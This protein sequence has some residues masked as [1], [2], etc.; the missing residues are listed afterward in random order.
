MFWTKQ[1]H[2]HH[3]TGTYISLFYSDDSKMSH[4]Y[5]IWVESLTLI[6]KLACWFNSR[7]H[8]HWNCYDRSV[9]TRINMLLGTF[10]NLHSSVKWHAHSTTCAH[11]SLI[12]CHN[13]R[14]LCFQILQ[15]KA[16][17]WGPMWV[18]VVIWRWLLTLK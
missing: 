13:L 16:S 8:H 15:K 5:Y 6:E 3:L 14:F 18:V 7:R 11:I 17:M 12:S 2:P 10:A 9:P 1:K 4:Q